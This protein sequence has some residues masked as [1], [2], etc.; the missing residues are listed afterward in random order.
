MSFAKESSLKYLLILIIDFYSFTW[1][2][3]SSNQNRKAAARMGA[4]WLAAFERIDLLVSDRGS[5]FSFTLVRHLTEE[6]HVK[7]SFTT[8]YYQF[9]DET[10]ERMYKNVMKTCRSVYSKCNLPAENCPAIISSLQ[11]VLSQYPLKLM[12]CK[13]NTKHSCGGVIRAR[14]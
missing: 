14:F 2:H 9:A 7:H 4:K 8:D 6:T 5:N 10:V 3:P 12:S 1:L 11:G 13:K